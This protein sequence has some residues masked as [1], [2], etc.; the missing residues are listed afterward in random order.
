MPDGTITT[1]V[2]NSEQYFVII[3]LILFALFLKKG[4]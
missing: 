1:Y 4:N 3:A 2:F